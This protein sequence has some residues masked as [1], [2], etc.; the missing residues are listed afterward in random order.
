M[1]TKLPEARRTVLRK[2]TDITQTGGSRLLSPAL[3]QKRSASDRTEPYERYFRLVNYLAAAQLYLKDN[4]LLEQ[5]LKPEH[6]KERLLGHWGT[7]PGLNL[8][9][10]HLNQL[11][12]R[13]D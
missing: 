1:Q 10:L 12:I 7:C 5:P 9:Y 6:I 4:V 13:T 3:R 11:I 8:I 2:G